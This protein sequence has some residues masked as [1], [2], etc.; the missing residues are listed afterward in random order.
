MSRIA[1]GRPAS[2]PGPPRAVGRAAT[3]DGHG[4][5]AMRAAGRCRAAATRDSGRVGCPLPSTTRRR[6]QPGGTTGNRA[7]GAGGDAAGRLRARWAQDPT[8]TAHPGRRRRRRRRRR[9]PDPARPTG[10][11][12]GR[13]RRIAAASDGREPEV[14]TAP[15]VR[16]LRKSES[17]HRCHGCRLALEAKGVPSPE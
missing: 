2:G 7:A 14:Q 17:G 6:G 4:G 10:R 8:T 16:R 9:R 3:G 11:G 1:A 15:F 5:Q 13:A 12:P